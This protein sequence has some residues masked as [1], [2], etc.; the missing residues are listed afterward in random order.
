MVKIQFSSSSPEGPR[1]LGRSQPK[2]TTTWS[3]AR[4]PTVELELTEDPAEP[5]M[6]AQIRWTIREILSTTASGAATCYGL[7]SVPGAMLERF[8]ELAI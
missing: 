4:D 1:A 6:S 8:P 2:S 7:Q 3:A 5:T